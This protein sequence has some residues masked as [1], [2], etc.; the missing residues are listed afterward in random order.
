[1]KVNNGNNGT[2]FGASLTTDRH[3]NPD[4]AYN[5]NGLNNYINIPHTSALMLIGVDFSISAWVTHSG[6]DDWDKTIVVKSD[7]PNIHNKWIF[8]YKPFNS[9]R[10]LGFAAISNGSEQN[11]GGYVNNI[12]FNDWYHYC[13]TRTATELKFYINGVLVH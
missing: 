8:W 13:M 9:P 12:V 3:G 7:G 1:M 2:V 11:L 6:I 5:F 10:G 4:K